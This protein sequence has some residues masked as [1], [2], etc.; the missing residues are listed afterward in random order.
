MTSNHDRNDLAELSR[1]FDSMLW[2]VT[3]LWA[4]A[5]GGLLVY[6]GEHEHFDPWIATFGLGLTVCA[7]YFAYSFRRFR[8]RV[9][10]A[11]PEELRGLVVGDSCVRQ[12][13]VFAIVFLG[14]VLLWAKVLIQNSCVLWWLWLPLAVAAGGLVVLM[15]K[16]ERWPRG[17]DA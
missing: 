12:W 17:P 9:H 13:D 8:R 1:H 14:L 11:M 2:T 5:V 10:N 4:G 16:L 15:W 7:M 6:S 3:S